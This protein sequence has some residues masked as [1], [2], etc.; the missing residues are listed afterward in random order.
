[1]HTGR[2][3]GQDEGAGVELLDARGVGVERPDLAVDSG[4]AQ[5]PGDQLRD[6]AA[7]IENQDAFGGGGGINDGIRTRN[8]A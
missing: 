8:W 3:A 1:M 2:T 7:E 4:F 6:L 5:P